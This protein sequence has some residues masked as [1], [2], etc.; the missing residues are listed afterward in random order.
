MMPPSEWG[1]RRAPPAAWEA[2]LF[3]AIFPEGA[4]LRW[5]KLHLFSGGARAGRHCL[6][7]VEALDGAG[8]RVLL[9]ATTDRVDKDARPLSVDDFARAGDAWEVRAPGVTWRADDDGTHSIAM[10][11]ARVRADV[12]TRDVLWWSRIPRVLSYASAF[13]EV[14]WHGPHGTIAGLGIAEHAWGAD[15]R[16]DVFRLAPKRWQWDVLWTGED[17]VCA[18]L[19]LGVAGALRGVRTGGRVPTVPFST[20]RTMRI[21]VHEWREQDA[22]R[23][24]ARWEGEMHLGAGVLRY[25]AHAST[26]VAPM[27]DGGGFL[28]AT[29]EGEWRARNASTPSHPVSGTGFTEYRASLPPS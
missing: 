20:G 4:A 27:F 10:D 14:R 16:L 25:E 15:T 29:F 3:I 9:T 19:A 24:P 1:S 22:R 6:S 12:R 7:A 21:R 13:G 11:D 17:A 2:Y 18:G 8:E 26:P 23:V 5:C 28:G